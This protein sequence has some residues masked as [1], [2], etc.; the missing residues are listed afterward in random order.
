MLVDLNFVS[1]EQS[2]H[3][4]L[5]CLR[6]RSH[7]I[8]NHSRI[9]HRHH[10]GVLHF[11]QVRVAVSILISRVSHVNSGLATWFYLR[12]TDWTSASKPR[13]YAIESFPSW[14]HQVSRF[15]RRRNHGVARDFSLISSSQTTPWKPHQPPINRAR[16]QWRTSKSIAKSVSNPIYPMPQR[17]QHNNQLQQN[18]FN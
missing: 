7:W 17:T 13:Q 5:D 14:A 4:F 8:R 16:T 9:H 15:Y 3:R 11:W 10:P 2:Y 12:F 1:I 6:F 18:P